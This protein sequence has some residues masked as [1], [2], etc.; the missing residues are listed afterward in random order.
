[1]IPFGIALTAWIISLFVR[2]LCP[3][4]V[5]LCVSTRA[6]LGRI[7]MSLLVIGIITFWSQIKGT[8]NR[9][10]IIFGELSAMRANGAVD[11][12][13]GNGGHLRGSRVKA[14]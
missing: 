12:A 5:A 4:D 2:A 3:S 1:M 11:I 14:D 6:T 7:Y 10:Y 9:F 13:G 8:V